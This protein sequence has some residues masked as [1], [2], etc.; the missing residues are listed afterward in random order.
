[1]FQANITLDADY[2]NR[3]WFGTLQ[4]KNLKPLR[5][6]QIHVIIHVTVTK[7]LYFLKIEYSEKNIYLITVPYFKGALLDK[8][9]TAR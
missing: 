4:C 1:M 5:Y 9:P 3:F 2:T 6:F 7:N 8:D